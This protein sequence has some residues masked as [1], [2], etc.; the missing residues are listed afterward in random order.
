[1]NLLRTDG[2]AYIPVDYRIY[3]KENDDKTKNDHFQNMLKKAK[4]RAFE[5]LYVLM[6]WLGRKSE[7]HYQ[8]TVV[9]LHLLAQIK[10]EGLRYQRSL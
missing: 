7:T 10:P 2:E 3:Q 9:E 1:M 8:R 4:E 6:V 5:P